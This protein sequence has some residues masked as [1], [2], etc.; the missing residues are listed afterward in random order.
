MKIYLPIKT[1][2]EANRASHEHWRKRC[3]RAKQQRAVAN[4]LLQEELHLCGWQ[5]EWI[6]TNITFTRIAPR[7]LD[8]GVNLPSAFKAIEDGIAD[9]LGVN[10]RDWQPTYQQ[11][12]GKPREYAVEVEIEIDGNR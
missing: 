3:R 10:D 7:Y 12:K 5:E 4:A 11:R 8:P 2:S 6:V 1:V 9:A